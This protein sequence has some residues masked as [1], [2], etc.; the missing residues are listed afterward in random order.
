VALYVH[1]EKVDEAWD[2]YNTI[3][4]IKWEMPSNSKNTML[5]AKEPL[6]NPNENLITEP[7]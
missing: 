4:W 5:I 6:H 1:G 3:D 2:G 7:L